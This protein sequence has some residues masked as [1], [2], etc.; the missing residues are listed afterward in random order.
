MDFAG[1]DPEE[2]PGAG[3]TVQT[4]SVSKGTGAGHGGQGGAHIESEF[5]KAYDSVF[6][7]VFSGSGGGNSSI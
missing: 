3:K 5:G 7:P 4:G 1:F 6:A 2:G